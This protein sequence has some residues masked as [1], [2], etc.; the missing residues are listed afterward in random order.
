MILYVI[1]LLSLDMMELTSSLSQIPKHNTSSRRNLLQN[2]L[3]KSLLGSALISASLAQRA[4]ALG[5]CRPKA[6]N[7]IR[8]KWEAP[9]TL[10]EI[11]AV[12]TIRD[13]LN[14]YP[15]NGQNGIDCNGWSIVNDSL[16]SSPSGPTRTLQLEFRSCI[17]P[18]A[19]AINLAQPFVDDV[20]LELDNVGSNG[21]ITVQVKSS[22]RMGS[23]DLFVNKKRIEYLGNELRQKHGWIVPDIKYGA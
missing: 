3:P 11:Q 5:L 17:G 13:I 23:S 18:A 1:F 19:I 20:I 6:R 21:A 14:S 16:S 8:T 22:S 2:T 15:Q 12:E 4:D 7:C 9:G 10:S